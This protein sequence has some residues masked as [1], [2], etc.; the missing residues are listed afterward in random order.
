MPPGL[1]RAVNALKA[2]QA[3]E[4]LATGTAYTE[5]GRLAVDELGEPVWPEWNSDGFPRVTRAAGVRRMRTTTLP[6]RNIKAKARRAPRRRCE[7]APDTA[8]SIR[9]SHR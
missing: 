1:I 2:R 3:T 9:V 4:K 5:S 8:R 6:V 7:P